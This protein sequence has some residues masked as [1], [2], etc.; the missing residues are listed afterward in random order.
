M[1]ILLHPTDVALKAFADSDAPSDA[2][3]RIAEHLAACI[4]CRATVTFMRTLR[5]RARALPVPAAPERLIGQ[6]LA[7][8]ASGARHILPSLEP[9]A[10]RGMRPIIRVAI[11][12][13]IAATLLAVVLTNRVPIDAVD[14]AGARAPQFAETSP[15][16]SLADL[17]APAVA[18]AQT[19]STAG[20]AA[21]RITGVDGTRLTPRQ[22][23]FEHRLVDAAG[24]I[25]VDGV[26]DLSL[27]RTTLDGRDAWMFIELSSGRAIEAETTYVTRTDLRPLGR[28]VH[29]R[30]YGSYKEIVVRQ[31]FFLDSIIG[32]MNTDR[33]IGRR[34][35]R[36]VPRKF[37][38]YLAS[39][40]IAPLFLG[41]V[42][43]GPTWSGSL[44]LVGWAVIPNDLFFPV[45][46]RV[47]GEERVVVPAG[48]FDCWRLTLTS[49]GRTIDYW[50]RK[51]D[52]VGVKTHQR[53][54]A[55][56]G[57]IREVVLIQG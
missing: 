15:A 11:G 22:V 2:R 31:R 56:D 23:R 57:R 12:T 46:M 10:A 51:T 30:P 48:T 5:E 40:G 41:S 27:S 18:L 17:F 33:T 29:V 19:A 47:D 53:T 38:P 55:P 9:V 43:L 13:A 6:V 49:G 4:R 21:P 14:P 3:D 8:R 16:S 32:W 36:E 44:S 35:A 39:E 54:P 42:V 34:I 37:G 26:S 20:P 25:T 24:T 52:G 1:M 45:A 7:E 28:L 50:V